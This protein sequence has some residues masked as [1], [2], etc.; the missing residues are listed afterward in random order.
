MATRGLGTMRAD[1]D[2][3]QDLAHVESA[4]LEPAASCLPSTRSTSLS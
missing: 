4:G 1:L 2:S 3:N